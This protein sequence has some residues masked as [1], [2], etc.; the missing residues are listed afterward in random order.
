MTV[1]RHNLDIT[2]L[3]STLDMTMALETEVDQEPAP[4]QI[5]EGVDIQQD[6]LPVEV[7]V[8]FFVI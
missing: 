4:P 7:S 8:S 6:V 3:L 1:Q 2:S 5:L